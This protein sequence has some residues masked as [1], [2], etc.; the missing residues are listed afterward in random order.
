MG[1]AN[2][3]LAALIDRAGLSNAGL[4]RRVNLLGAERRLS[5][6]HAS[7]AR[8]IRDGAIPRDPGPDLICQVI[9]DALKTTVTRADIGMERR[10]TATASVPLPQLVERATALWRGDQRDK[11]AG[12]PATGAD[13]V[14]PVWEWENPPDDV[15]V[16]RAGRRHVDAAD[17]QRLR[18]LRAR[19]QE[20]YRRVGGVPTRP[21]LVAALNEHT[22]PLLRD[23]YDNRVGRELFRAAGGLAAL[24]GVCAYDADQ[25]GLAQRYLFGALRMAKASGDKRFGAY[26]VALLSTHALHGNQPRLV[27]QYAE[28]AL[29]AARGHLTPA[30]A[31]DLHSLAGKAYARMGDSDGCQQH[32]RQSELVAARI[33]LSDEP[34]EAS[35][36]Q[37]GLVETQVAEALR[38]LG[39][40]GAAQTYAEE[41]VRMAAGTHLRGRVHRYAGLALIV[42]QRGDVDQAVHVGT[43]MLEYAEGMESGRIRDRV[44]QVAAALRPHAR[45]PVVAEFLERADT[46]TQLRGF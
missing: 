9:G 19:Y 21:R 42:A 31:A 39:D 23:A 10:P 11:A 33:D 30:L 2:L 44:A 34:A 16:A 17:V 40:F 22:A 18:Q 15:D 29:R 1:E 3:L 6:D 25:Q 38:R 13:A 35:Y 46:D 8:W 20:M 12:P 4:A 45:V 41:S 7:V 28:A 27:V 24:A 26:V 43:Q 32:M 5:Y 36:V 14:A 37:P